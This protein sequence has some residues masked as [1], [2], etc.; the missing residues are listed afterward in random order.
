MSERPTPLAAASGA[1]APALVERARAALAEG[2][3]C[4]LPTETVYGLA[5]RADRP[6]A[7]DELRRIKGRPPEL[8]FTWHV[9]RRDV[10]DGFEELR[11]L[12]RRLAE[13][14]WPGPLSLVLHG[15]PPGLEGIAREGWT[16]VRL[17]AHAA[18]A[19][20]LT[21]CDFPV[22]MSSANRHGE[23]PLLSAE[24]VE[25]AFGSELALVLDG[26]PARLGEA[27][28]VLRLG[29]GRFEL[30]REGL[31]G[32]DELRRTA[33]LRLAFVC[34]GNTCRSPMA[35]ALA[36]RLLATRL[37]GANAGPE[38]LARFGFEVHSMGVHAA[39]GAPASSGTQEALA[40]RGIDTSAHRS[41][42]ATPESLARLDRIYGLTQGHVEA[43]RAAL[44]PGRYAPVE[45][46]DPRRD[47]ADP[48]GGGPEVYAR[49]LQEIE[50]ALEQRL[51][52]WA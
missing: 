39:S 45:R 48:I 51:G 19:A 52:E 50:R 30:L 35:E 34:T 3:V 24:E 4:A 33:G 37:G 20:V 21:A 17:P 42:Q 8:T 47:I 10:L 26:G 15:T 40:A 11:P 32:L 27:S 49:A 22:V 16:G 44:P 6:A 31:L 43:L 7:L 28:A 9:A 41:R 5:A 12:A 14:Y 13:R 18:T 1:P 2:R 25:R 29:V 23:R 46:L 38:V 36:R